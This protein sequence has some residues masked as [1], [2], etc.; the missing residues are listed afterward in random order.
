MVL[1]AAQI[2]L[3]REVKKSADFFDDTTHRRVKNIAFD[4][5]LIG[6]T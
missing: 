2:Y 1:H 6:C 3:R 5:R 4:A